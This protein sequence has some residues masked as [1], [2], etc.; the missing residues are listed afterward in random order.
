[1][2]CYLR[3]IQKE[4]GDAGIEVNKGNRKEVD[5]AIHKV[6]GVDHKDCPEAWRH[7]KAMMAEDKEGF[8][9]KLRE[10]LARS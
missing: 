8:L 5:K 7:V 4:L 1:M 10:E 2:S 3:H 9:A 6:V